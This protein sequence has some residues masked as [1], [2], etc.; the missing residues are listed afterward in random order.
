[1]AS[2]AANSASNQNVFDVFDGGIRTEDLKIETVALN[3]HERLQCFLKEYHLF[4]SRM[5]G[6][7]HSVMA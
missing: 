1:L 6:L 2:Q 7:D 3:L 4:N 5:S